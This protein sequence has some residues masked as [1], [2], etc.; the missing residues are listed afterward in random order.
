MLLLALTV[1]YLRESRCVDDQVRMFGTYGGFYR[2]WVG[3][4]KLGM[5]IR[6][7]DHLAR[8]HDPRQSLS[9]HPPGPGDHYTHQ[10]DSLPSYWRW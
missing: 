6:T 1:I 2:L 3:D 8:I 7:I 4:I 10:V 5:R 9:E